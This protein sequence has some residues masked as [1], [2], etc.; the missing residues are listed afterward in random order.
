MW[1]N[2]MVSLGCFWAVFATPGGA[3][4][5]RP[6]VRAPIIVNA[7]TASFASPPHFPALQA[8]WAIG[9]E[10]R[11]EPYLIL[12]KL[13]DGAKIP[14]HS[15]PDARIMTVVSGELSVGFGDVVNEPAMISVKAGDSFLVRENTPHYSRA[16]KGD[17]EYQEYG[18]GPTGTLF[19][20][21][22]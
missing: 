8:A 12:V 16:S 20:T 18:H 1:Q 19:V 21:K 2:G 11:S 3:F 7:R 17:V 9:E 5:E 14:P 6:S 10:K 13:K 22:P 15:H 4:A